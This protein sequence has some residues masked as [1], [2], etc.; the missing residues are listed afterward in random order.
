M[1]AIKAL[2]MTAMSGISIEPESNC[3]NV[4]QFTLWKWRNNE[5]NFGKKL[6]IHS[7]Q[8]STFSIGSFS[9]ETVDLNVSNYCLF[10]L[11]RH[12]LHIHLTNQI[13]IIFEKNRK[14]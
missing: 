11:T 3:L 10:S 4:V 14:N 2:L 7:M 9:C 13:I 1:A 6:R 5:E 8:S 12:N